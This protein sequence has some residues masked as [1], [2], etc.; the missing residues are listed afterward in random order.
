MVRKKTITLTPTQWVIGV[1]VVVAFFLSLGVSYLDFSRPSKRPSVH[2]ILSKVKERIVYRLKSTGDLFTFVELQQEFSKN[3]DLYEDND[4][5]YYLGAK[6]NSDP[7]LKI[8]GFTDP[9][10][11]AKA[12][13]SDSVACVRLR[14]Q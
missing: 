13:A 3:L 14:E 4:G 10:C 7:S 11:H 2:S 5:S 9:E 1:S 12:R 8:D 6:D